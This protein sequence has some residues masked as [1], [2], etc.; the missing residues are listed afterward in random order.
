[1]TAAGWE[2]CTSA[3]RDLPH[4]LQPEC[5]SSGSLWSADEWLPSSMD[6]FFPWEK[7]SAKAQ[8]MHREGNLSV[9][10]PKT[11]IA[12]M[13]AGLKYTPETGQLKLA[14]R[15][16]RVGCKSQLTNQNAHVNSQKRRSS[17]WELISWSYVKLSCN[18][19]CRAVK[20]TFSFC[21]IV[22]ALCRALAQIFSPSLHKSD[23]KGLKMLKIVWLLALVNI[24]YHLT[25]GS[26]WLRLKYSRV[27]RERMTF[28]DS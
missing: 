17:S 6:F 1:M 15:Q 25:T 13:P 5:T 12:H 7:H 20:E 8:S 16:N 26:V 18:R 22:L 27:S 24:I 2:R 19:I 11:E 3:E 9:N 21:I 4:A 10:H 14:V 28:S 23:R